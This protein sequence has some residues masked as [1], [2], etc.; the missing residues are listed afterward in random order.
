[1]YSG[2]FFKSTLESLGPNSRQAGLIEG[3]YRSLTR[4][5]NAKPV[6]GRFSSTGFLKF[7]DCSGSNGEPLRALRTIQIPHRN[8]GRPRRIEPPGYPQK[9]NN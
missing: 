3:A 5:T 7:V 6:A 9:T 2:L 4:L 1:M 8:L